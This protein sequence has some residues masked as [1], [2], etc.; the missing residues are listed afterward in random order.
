MHKILK[1]KKISIAIILIFLVFYGYYKKSRSIDILNSPL[2][3]FSQIGAVDIAKKISGA[4][5]K[6]GFLVYG[7]YLPMK[8]GSYAIN[9]Q[10]SLSNLNPAED[11][12]KTVGF[13]DVN[14]A[15]NPQYNVRYDFKVKDFLQSN[16]HEFTL[17]FFIPQN[18]PQVEFRVFQ[19]AGQN[20]SLQSLRLSPTIRYLFS[21]AKRSLQ[22][23]FLYLLVGLPLF[24]I[25]FWMAHKFFLLK[26]VHAVVI[27]LSIVV[28]QYMWLKNT[29]NQDILKGSYPLSTQVGVKD[30]VTKRFIGQGG[31]NGFLVYG[32]YMPLSQ[33]EYEITYKLSL[34]NK[35]ANQNQIL[36]FCD[37]NIV[38][39]PQ[40][41]SRVE[42][43]RDIFE[44]KN[45][46]E[47]K[48]RFTIPQ[49]THSTEFRVFQ[50]GGNVLT[51]RSLSLNP[52]TFAG[53][54][55]PHKQRIFQNVMYMC[56][57][58]LLISLYIKF[59]LMSKDRK[60]RKQ[61]LYTTLLPV[62]SGLL[63]AYI[64][65]YR[66]ISA[67]HVFRDYY[68]MWRVFYAPAW[69]PLMFIFFNFL[70]FLNSYFGFRIQIEKYLRYDSYTL[71]IFPLFIIFELSLKNFH[72][73]L[74]LGNLYLIPLVIKSLIYFIF[75]WQNLKEQQHIE[76]NKNVKR[77]IFL[78]IFT[79]YLLI[80][81][82]VNAAFH[83]DGD[84][85]IYLLK[86]QTII[87]DNDLDILNNSKNGDVLSYHPDVSWTPWFGTMTSSGTSF[88]LIPGFLIAGRFGAVLTM[89]I[90]GALIALNIFILTMLM[91]C[92]IR[93]A[94]CGM[95]IGAFSSPLG[96]YSFLTYP[97]IIS[98][99]IVIYS[100]RKILSLGQK[101]VISILNTIF[102]A[103]ILIILKE[104]YVILSAMI[105]LA[106]MYK[107]R[108]NYK[109]IGIFV[110]TIAAA[111]I[112]YVMYDK[113]F[114]NS[115][116]G[117][118]L[119]K[120][121]GGLKYYLQ[122]YKQLGKGI[123]GIL[124]LIF[125]QECGLLI[126]A[127]VYFLSLIGMIT[128]LKRKESR[129]GALLMSGIF[130][131]YFLTVAFHG[132]WWVEG[133][134][135]PRFIVVITPI[136]SIV[137]GIFLTYSK[138]L[139]LKLFLFLAWLWSL[140]V[141]YLLVLIP[142]I[143]V[144]SPN[145]ITGH[146]EILDRLYALN[147]LP[148]LTILFPSFLKPTDNTYFLTILFVIIFTL[149]AFFYVKQ[150]KQPLEMFN[151][152]KAVKF[153]IV[154]MLVAGFVLGLAKIAYHNEQRFEAAN[155]YTGGGTRVPEGTLLNGGNF[156]VLT[157]VALRKGEKTIIKIK[158]KAVSNDGWP[159]LNIATGT[160]KLHEKIGQIEINSNDWQEYRIEY[161][162]IRGG[163]LPFW[164]EY[165][166]FVNGRAIIIS[167]I[168]FTAEK[169]S[170][171]LNFIKY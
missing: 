45:P 36:G 38:D 123:K 158:A 27:F 114:I 119:S 81:P 148:N 88:T 64:W 85:T 7:P 144:H 51:L 33:G 147:I 153:S 11:P 10:L 21:L 107:I 167:E 14:V 73:H 52:A 163:L 129:P 105:L 3:L 99:L 146:N 83:T 28:L 102:L 24:F 31:G 101:K 53:L 120:I 60:M 132:N 134:P 79:V 140:G 69:L 124:G 70:Y 93:S 63:M 131:P 159:I 86:T 151:L 57:V 6:E 117:L 139:W 128:A 106:L 8:E 156:F 113:L 62:V 150:Q 111:V 74:V 166:T 78:S 58:L 155:R 1:V 15:D 137:T 65:Q 84:E 92:S 162:P 149:L 170:Q 77:S 115:Y 94:Y 154:A 42:L 168:I 13:C 169:K 133:S 18:K 32:P 12:Q 56:G 110:V 109:V 37:V 55:S 112:M 97:E 22:P 104:R 130:L 19:Y 122:A 29:S 90:I 54:I 87:K 26:P 16:P 67:Q 72:T 50:M 48:L 161:T 98:A 160:N 118:G 46:A 96:I 25:M 39:A 108:K 2:P 82:W 20:L 34:D 142:Q 138:K 71:L 35:E 44:K 17:K 126:Y 9:Y 157:K 43:N 76:S 41:N 164:F 40:N 145:H 116:E 23:I 30:Q 89:N 75:L 47:I 171:W 5:G 61:Y 80:T 103:G 143:R 135:A 125:D 100:I 141:Y 136:L 95:L 4:E 127:P 121:V 152:G 49:G 59:M 91:T 165:V 68:D 66:A